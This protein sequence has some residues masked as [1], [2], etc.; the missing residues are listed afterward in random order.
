M[1]DLSVTPGLPVP[2]PVPTAISS[3]AGTD[4]KISPRQTTE[5]GP[6]VGFGYPKVD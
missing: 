2:V 1:A 5:N 4:K 3:A 6:G